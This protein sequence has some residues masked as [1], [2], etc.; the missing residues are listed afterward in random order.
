MFIFLHSQNIA[1]PCLLDGVD[2]QTTP[3]HYLITH[4]HTFMPHT[5]MKARVCMY[6]LPALAWKGRTLPKC[7]KN[8]VYRKAEIF[9]CSSVAACFEQYLFMKSANLLE[10]VAI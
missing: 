7:W 9:H 2:H 3:T 5:I 1:A 4:V 6:S 10:C 8:I